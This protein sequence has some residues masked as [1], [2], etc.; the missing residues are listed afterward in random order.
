MR[1]PDPALV[2]LVGASGADSVTYC[3]SKG[4]SC[5]VGSVLCGSHEFIRR[6]RKYRKMVGGCMRQAGIMA[7]AAGLSVG[8]V[9]G[10]RIGGK[11]TQSDNPYDDMSVLKG[12]ILGAP[13]GGAAGA[14]LG[15][16]LTDR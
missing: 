7:A 6:A 5:P 13:I 10:M 8:W 2:V 9:L 4:L 12:A 16:R 3:L 14:I 11:L 15:W 1:L